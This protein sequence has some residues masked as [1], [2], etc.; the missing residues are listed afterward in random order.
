MRRG[1]NRWECATCMQSTVKFRQA[2][3]N[4]YPRISSEC[5]LSSRHDQNAELLSSSIARKNTAAR[6]AHLR[7]A[8]G[9]GLMDLG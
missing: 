7:R 4:N 8:V 9:D 1:L 5:P 6:L 3:Q 2:H